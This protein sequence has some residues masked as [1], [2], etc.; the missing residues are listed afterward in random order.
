MNQKS[1]PSDASPSGGEAAY[2]YYLVGFIDILGQK[3]R[4]RKIKSLPVN[5][6]EYDAFVKLVQETH[7][8]VL[9]FRKSFLRFFDGMFK[10]RPTPT[11]L[12]EEQLAKFEELRKRAEKL[13]PTIVPFTDAIVIYV[14]LSDDASVIQVDGILSTILA[15]SGSFLACIALGFVFRGG[16]EIGLARRISANEIYGPAL[17]QAY[18]LECKVA[19]YPRVVVG[20]ELISF[21]KLTVANQDTETQSKAN[22][23]MAQKC[24]DLLM[25]DVDGRYAIDYLG[26]EYRRISQSLFPDVPEKASSFLERVFLEIKEKRNTEL[27]LRYSWLADYFEN[28]LSLWQEPQ[29]DKSLTT[30]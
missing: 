18:D 29:M 17:V 15:I 4:L 6:E 22:K 9:S 23:V 24:L 10:P 28:R 25:I 1:E 27:C 16:V 20:D 14:P 19:K 26:E 30:G 11:G 13:K 12:T 8:T 2:R 7:G 21:L 3:E 5:K